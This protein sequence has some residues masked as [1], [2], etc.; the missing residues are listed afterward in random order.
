MSASAMSDGV[1]GVDVP[2]LDAVAGAFGMT[3][4]ISG[5]VQVGPV[6]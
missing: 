5:I 6:M 1:D 3:T 4:G 2:S